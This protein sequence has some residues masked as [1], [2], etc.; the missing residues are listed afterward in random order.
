MFASSKTKFMAFLRDAIG[1]DDSDDD[2]IL[3]YTYFLRPDLP[4]EM[5]M[6]IKN[7]ISEEALDSIIA[8]IGDKIASRLSV[9]ERLNGLSSEERLNGLSSEER[10]NGLSPEERLNGLSSEELVSALTPEQRRQLQ[11][12]LEQ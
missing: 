5:N 6:S 7:R 12:L 3:T 10:L 8:D 2:A 4:E 1:R 9:E 11:Q